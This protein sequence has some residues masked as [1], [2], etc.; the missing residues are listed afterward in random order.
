MATQSLA[1]ILA[2]RY[3]VKRGMA[4]SSQAT[5]NEP[6]N[7]NRGGKVGIV[8]MTDNRVC[9][10]CGIEKDLAGEF[11]GNGRG[12]HDKL[13]KECRRGARFS[14]H[15]DNRLREGTEACQCQTCGLYFKSEAAFDRH[16]LFTTE[17]HDWNKRR[18]MTVAEMTARG[19]ALNSKG[20]WVT[21]LYTR[22]SETEED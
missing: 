12:G 18:C 20:L 3:G 7:Q 14:Q 2:R 16:R 22:A 19:M 4:R 11:Y 6:V 9:R 15:V 13:C 21:S 5:P 17:K 1:A 8:E 10:G